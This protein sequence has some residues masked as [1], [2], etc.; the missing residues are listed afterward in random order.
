[1]FKFASVRLLFYVPASHKVA[2][3]GV[4]HVLNSFFFNIEINALL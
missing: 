3:S 2:K 1:M 4:V